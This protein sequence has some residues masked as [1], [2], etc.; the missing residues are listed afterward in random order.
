MMREIGRAV[1]GKLGPGAADQLVGV[2]GDTQQRA[3]RGDDRRFLA[4]RGPDR[5]SEL[6]VGPAARSAVVGFDDDCRRARPDSA[7]ASK[8]P[9]EIFDVDQRQPARAAAPPSA[10]AWP[11]GT[12]REF[13]CRRGHRPPAGGPSPSRG[14]SVRPVP[15]PAPWTRR[16][17]TVWARAR[18]AKRRGRSGG[19][20][21]RSPRRASPAS[22]RHCPA[23]NRRRRLALIAPATWMTAS[24]SVTSLRSASRSSRLPG[25]HS[26]ASSRR[27]I[28]AGQCPDRMA[29][30]ERGLDQM[31]TDEAGAARD[32]ELHSGG[33]FTRATRAAPI[34]LPLVPA[35]RHRRDIATILSSSG[36]IPSPSGA[37]TG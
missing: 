12:A 17:A 33:V 8:Q 35:A 22:R 23:R 3:G 10:R 20:R 13:P 30:A 5:A 2:R 14:R 29:G 15:R 11:S 7:S 27:L 9:R 1:D 6:A 24:A 34:R 31:R 37:E 16:R 36:S 21:R 4:D 26:S 25:T 18:R 19:P 28:A 32:R